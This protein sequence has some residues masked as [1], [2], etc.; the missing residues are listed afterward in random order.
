[1]GAITAIGNSPSAVFEAA[2]SGRSGVRPAP[3]LAVGPLIPLVASAVFDPE[4][5]ILRQRS[6]PMDRATAM[7]VAAARQA[8]TDA[9]ADFAPG[10]PLTGIYWGTGMGAAGTLEDGYRSV[11]QENNWRLK[12]T[13]IVT[14]MNNAPAALISLEYGVTGPTL[15]YSVACS[16]S[17]V[18]IGEAM[19]AIRH[20]IIDCAIVGGSE[21]MLTRGMLSAWSALRTL[22]KH[23]SQD[24]SRSCKP[25]SSDRTGFV[26]GEGAAALVLENVDRA[27]ERGARIYAELAG[28]GLTSDA[29]HIAE[30]S[31]DG[32]SR[33]IG[34]ALR[35]AGIS[36]AEIGYINAHGTATIAGD[37]VEV[38]SIRR[39]FGE[40]AKGVAVSSTKALHGHALGATG[41]IEFMIAL[42]A[43]ESGSLPPTAHL[44]RPDPEL[45]LDFV[46]NSARHGVSLSAVVSNSFAFGGSNAV[47]VARKMMTSRHLASG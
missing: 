32:Q 43:L 9:G 1:M 17:A 35:D 18:A 11:F 6:A 7:A 33:A 24:V 28:F 15:T 21:A 2:L 46:P 23:D 47:L 14:G 37:R 40:N 42:L 27:L 30:P 39:V 31:P 19:R 22:A 26:L 44:T 5:V 38:T 29:T 13:S 20:G 16:S 36:P 3:E 34:A 8:V 4:T 12:P 10:S 25:F 41:A 45:D